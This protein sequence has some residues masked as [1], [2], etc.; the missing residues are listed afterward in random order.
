MSTTT[1]CALPIQLHWFLFDASSR[2]ANASPAHQHSLH[3]NVWPLTK[4]Q[5]SSHCHTFAKNKTANCMV[6]IFLFVQ[7]SFDT[8][9]NFLSLPAP[10]PCE[11]LAL[12]R[13]CWGVFWMP[14]HHFHQLG[15]Q[16]LDV[17]SKC[18]ACC[19]VLGVRARKSRKFALVAKGGG[20]PLNSA[21]SGHSSWIFQKCDNL[22]VEQGKPSW[23]PC[24]FRK[25]P[26]AFLH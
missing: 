7:E 5:M 22:T 6:G 20:W 23:R 9:H 14:P 26:V 8:G 16:P 18:T 24:F 17:Q 1:N 4:K 11:S 15:H 10:P 21:T 13:K 12:E 3:E 19:W 25:L 2:Q